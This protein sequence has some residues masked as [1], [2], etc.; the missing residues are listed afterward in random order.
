MRIVKSEDEFQ[1]NLESAKRE[2][3]KAFKDDR[4]KLL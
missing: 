4:V 2:S 3:A 1:E